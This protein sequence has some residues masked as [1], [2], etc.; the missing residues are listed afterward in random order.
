MNYD[1][2]YND[3]HNKLLE[4]S[5]TLDVTRESWVGVDRDMSNGY[6]TWDFDTE[7]TLQCNLGDPGIIQGDLTVL[8]WCQNHTT[9]QNIIN[10]VLDVL[11]PTV[12][13]KRKGIGPVQLTNTF[14]HW[15]RLDDTNPVDEIFNEKQGH[16]VPEVVGLQLNFLLKAS[17]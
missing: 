9:R 3:I 8:C 11:S 4:N 15:I 7:H 13:G 6:I 10:S 2:L 1:G 14:W 17:I 16:D 12:G 5:L